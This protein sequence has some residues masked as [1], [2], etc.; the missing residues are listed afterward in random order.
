MYETILQQPVFIALVVA[1]LLIAVTLVLLL[2]IEIKMRRLL[3]RK[4][5]NIEETLA[6]VQKDLRYLLQKDKDIKEILNTVESRLQKSVRGVHTVRFNP[7]HG[8]SGSNQSFATAFLNADGD[9][10]IVSSLY[11]RERVSVFAKPVQKFHSEYELT[12]EER[13]AVLKA[14][15]TIK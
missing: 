10:V 13:D 6:F 8:T 4:A 15:E 11:S 1:F 12:N 3:Y 9:G 14:Q 2:R 7:F 5:T